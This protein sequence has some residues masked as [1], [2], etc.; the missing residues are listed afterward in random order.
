[1]IDGIPVLDYTAETLLGIVVL[2]VFIGRLVPAWY[3]KQL[4]NR[5]ASLEKS[6][7]ILLDQNS[8]LLE[9]T[10]LARSTWLALTEGVKDS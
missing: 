2:L 6:N 8:E 4:E 10:R 3:V 5:V 1:M 7:K 9:T